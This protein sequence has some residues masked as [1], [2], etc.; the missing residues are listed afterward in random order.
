MAEDVVI[1]AEGLG[2]KYVIG[3]DAEREGYV[4]LRDVLARGARNL[5]RKTAGMARGR[6]LVAGDTHEEFWALKDV[7]FEVRRGEVL[8]IIGR[9]GAGKSTLLKILS[10]IT[11]PSEGRV[12]INGR[13]ASLLEVGTG[14]HPELTGR[15]NIYLNGAILG[16]SRAE[17]R[18]KFDEIVAFA[19]IEKF[20]DTPVKRYSSG[21]YVRL[22]F[23][24]AAHL[25]PEI[26]VVDEVLA[27][28]DAE[29][30]KRCLM[31]MDE[32]AT[33]GRT[34]LFVSHNL[35]AIQHLC[36]R[37]AWLDHARLR[38]A[39][40]DVR[41]VTNSYLLSNH[42]G[43]N[44]EWLNI[45]DNKSNNV[46]IPHRFWLSLNDD[47]APISYPVSSDQQ[48]WVNIELEVLAVDPA[49]NVGYALYTGDHNLLYWSCHADSSPSDWPQIEQGRLRI[50]SPL[51]RRLLNEGRYRADL[52]GYLH[53]R[54]WLFE[55][56]TQGPSIHFEIRG[57]LSDS[58]IWQGRR[59]G[60]LAPTYPWTRSGAKDTPLAYGSTQGETRQRSHAL[61]QSQNTDQ[62]HEGA[63][64]R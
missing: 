16:M 42:T 44:P 52:M 17:I 40:S 60:L 25:E 35:N 7:S 61:A 54:G 37:A 21:M 34:I 2:K 20:L 18:K 62:D 53:N 43:I 23:A 55:P 26:L 56:G 47:D 39:S 64:S 36:T 13:V 24:V 30:Q 49:V 48:A 50:R 14:F 45:S 57:G 63:T 32:V 10:R 11:E 41:A 15:E 46:A 51:P 12:T 31:K 59:P 1:R 33:E 4:A 38:T 3:H 6:A 29:F 28:G 27:V 22:A 19:E 5:G 9:N 58:P 8:G